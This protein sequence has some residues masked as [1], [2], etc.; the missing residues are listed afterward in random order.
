HD[1]RS[2]WVDNLY[3][4]MG[5]AYL[6]RKDFDSASAVFQYINYVYVPKDEGYDIPLGSNASNTGGV[7]TVAT[8]EQRPFL[9]KLTTTLPSRNEA[10]VW[11]VRTYLEQQ[12]T[13]DA[14]GLLEILRHDP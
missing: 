5:R 4:L 3:I 12:K 10:L 8:N 13:G 11:Q 6:L 9:K 7:F 14:A 1:L 2:D